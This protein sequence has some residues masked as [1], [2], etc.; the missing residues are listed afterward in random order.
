[1]LCYLHSLSGLAGFIVGVI[2][3]G[4]PSCWFSVTLR[5]QSDLELMVFGFLFIYPIGWSCLS[6]EGFLV[7]SWHTAMNVISVI[8]LLQAADIVDKCHRFLCEVRYF[9]TGLTISGPWWERRFYQ[10]VEY[11]QDIS[12]VESGNLQVEVPSRC[13]GGLLHI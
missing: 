1:M 6:G 12:E 8:C 3:F 10:R 2:L 4:W 7:E 9:V 11:L 13:I 5:L